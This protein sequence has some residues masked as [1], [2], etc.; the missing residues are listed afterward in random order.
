MNRRLVHLVVAFSA[1]LVAFHAAPITAGADEQPS[2]CSEL[3]GT[4]LPVVFVHGFG[5]DADMWRSGD[6]RATFDAVGRLGVATPIAFDY[7]SAHFEWVTD[8][9]IGPSLAR[10]VTCL[11]KRSTEQGGRGKVILVG[12]SMGGLAIREAAAEPI[13]RERRNVADVIGLAVT[14]GTPHG[15]T[16]FFT[17]LPR[18]LGPAQPAMAP[19]SRQLD[20]LPSLERSGVPALYLASTIYRQWLDQLQEGGDDGVVPASSAIPTQFPRVGP[21][22]G[23]QVFRCS[24][25]DCVHTKLP[26]APQVR[27][28]VTN[29]VTA[30]LDANPLRPPRAPQTTTTTATPRPP[31][32]T[33]AGQ[34]TIDFSAFAGEWVAHSAHLTVRANGTGEF[35]YRNYEETPLGPDASEVVTFRLTNITQASVEG[36][37][38]SS[39]DPAIYRPGG[40]IRIEYLEG[41]VVEITPP[42]RAS[43][44]CNPDAYSDTAC[45]A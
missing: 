15:G 1:L 40:Y 33:T 24:P 21:G 39:S 6:G 12:H 2:G 45:G 27:D 19:G 34:S 35:T 11:A 16:P 4:D 31:V 22:S 41:G 28:A 32:P 38:E 5:S 42:S 44:L 17:D 8:S 3:Q 36:T 30:W 7:R 23:T 43:T 37:I 10:L 26:G 13:F 29:A 18:P 14:I 9:R 25:F 20:R